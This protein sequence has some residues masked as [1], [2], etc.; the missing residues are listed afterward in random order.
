MEGLN[1]NREGKP[2]GN[3][4]LRRAQ[5]R[6]LNEYTI[7]QY[8]QGRQQSWLCGYSRNVGKHGVRQNNPKSH[9]IESYSHLSL[10]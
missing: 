4:I 8:S 3:R 2:A 6:Q 9:V 1:L 7:A 10:A 5:S